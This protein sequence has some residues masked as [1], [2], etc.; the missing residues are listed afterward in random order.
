MAPHRIDNPP[1]NLLLTP[2]HVRWRSTYTT[3]KCLW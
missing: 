3:Y 2:C 1:S